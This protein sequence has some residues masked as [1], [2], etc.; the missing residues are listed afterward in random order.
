[1]LTELVLDGNRLGAMTTAR[2]PAS[3]RECPAP[4]EILLRSPIT[5]HRHCT[6]NIICEPHPL[7][8]A[9]PLYDM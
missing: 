6:Y 4:L 2:F 7:E 3:M 5:T 8:K 1:M 9:P